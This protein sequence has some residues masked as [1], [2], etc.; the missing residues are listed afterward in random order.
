M[1]KGTDAKG[2]RLAS[3]PVP[4]MQFT[5]DIG[6]LLGF[7]PKRLNPATSNLERWIIEFLWLKASGFINI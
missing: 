3:P 4:V 5:N 2:N 1:P 7:C 6:S